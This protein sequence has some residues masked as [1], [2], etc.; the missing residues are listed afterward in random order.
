MIRLAV[1][2]LYTSRKFS[3]V[4]SMK[5]ISLYLQK[6]QFEFRGDSKLMAHFGNIFDV[7]DRDL[8]GKNKTSSYRVNWLRKL[9]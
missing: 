2:I 5:E 6:K 9:R 4:A 7:F 8:V 3:I 1:A